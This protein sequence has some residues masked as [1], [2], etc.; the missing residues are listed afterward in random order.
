MKIAPI[1]INEYER[2]RALYALN[3]LDTKPDEAF[4]RITRICK[5]LFNVESSAVCFVDE[6]RVWFKSI[7]GIKASE[8]PRSTSILW[9]HYLPRS[10][11]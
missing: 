1:P 11:R 2:L 3:I 7:Q 10:F 4:N 5:Q 6:E 8:I 9:P